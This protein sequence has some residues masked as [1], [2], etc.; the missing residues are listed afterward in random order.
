VVAQRAHYSRGDAAFLDD[1]PIYIRPD[2]PA[3]AGARSKNLVG[4]S[5]YA[6]AIPASLSHPHHQFRHTKYQYFII[7]I[8]HR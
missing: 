3:T 8:L 6:E 2:V 1:L 7:S 5:H 4:S